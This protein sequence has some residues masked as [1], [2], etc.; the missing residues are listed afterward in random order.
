MASVIGR[1]APRDQARTQGV[2]VDQGHGV[3][4][5]SVR[6]ARCEK[7]HDVRLLQLRGELDLPLEPLDVHALGQLRSQHFHDDLAPKCGFRRRKH[8]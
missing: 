6:L 2:A 5:E 8:P 3:V 4:G 1:G 7:R